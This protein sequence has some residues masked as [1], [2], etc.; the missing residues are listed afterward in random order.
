MVFL[1]HC[2][3]IIYFDG[4]VVLYYFNFLKDFIKSFI[5]NNHL[6]FL[7]LVICIFSTFIKIYSYDNIFIKY[8]SHLKMV[9]QLLSMKVH[10]TQI[11]RDSQLPMEFTMSSNVIG[12]FLFLFY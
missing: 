10:T 3:L 1:Y 8:H 4:K 6:K 9:N 11:C 7:F 12:Y 2:P 5:V